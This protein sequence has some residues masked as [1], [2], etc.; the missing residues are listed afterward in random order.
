M[1]IIN[2]Y[3]KLKE[4]YKEYLSSFISI[5]DTCIRDV[6]TTAI[7]NEQM[8]PDALIQFNPNFEQGIGVDEMISKGLPI[9]HELSQFFKDRFY[10]HQQQ[11]IELGCQGREFIVTSGTGSGKSRT[12][13]ATIFN[14]ILHHKEECEN[15]TIAIIVYPMNALINC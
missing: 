2:I 15:K 10:L 9:H 12:F 8:W 7:A 1:D 4:S 6:V 3:D 5:K 13:M 14:Y 11:A